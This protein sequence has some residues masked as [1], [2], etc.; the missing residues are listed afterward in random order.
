MTKV[1]III[2]NYNGLRFLPDCL[3]SV[4]KTEF[5]QEKFEVFFVDNASKDD[6]ADWVKKHYHQCR[7]VLNK[8]NLGF[9]E[10]NNVA[11]REAISQ[12]FKYIVL[13]NNDTV[14]EPDW[15][16]ELA[17]TA[18]S[19]KKIGA[20]QSLLLDYSEPENINTAGNKLHYLGFG[21]AG[22]YKEKL[23]NYK[24]EIRN[25]GI[26][27]AS[28]AAVLY[29]AEALKKT[30]IFDSDF[31]LYHEDL[32]L[33]WRL[34]L[35]GYKIVLAQDS[36][37][38]HKYSFSRNKNKYY[39]MERNRWVVL[40]SNYKIETLLLFLPALIIMEIIVLIFSIMQNSF[41]LKLKSYVSIVKFIPKILKR[42]EAIAK[43]RQ[44]QDKEVLK[45]S[46]GQ[47]EN[48]ELSQYKNLLDKVINP[49]FKWYLKTVRE[50]VKW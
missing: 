11:M 2:L 29:K 18:E 41:L 26:G 27:Y 16:S 34:R 4:F 12:N 22:H 32:D 33:G 36:V 25:F 8:K 13:L 21:W 44:V 28:G 3:S 50:A 47:I 42:R 24:L 37:V 43:F 45:Y 46:V 49:F 7:L 23:R 15:L 19:D 35:A 17:Q 48:Q 9:A 20:V 1:A 14:V 10:G 40:L 38:Y 5:P 6:S 39:F 31:F 30:G